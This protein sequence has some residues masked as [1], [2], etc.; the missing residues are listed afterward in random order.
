MKYDSGTIIGKRSRKISKV[1]HLDDIK[2]KPIYIAMLSSIK[3]LTKQN[4]ELILNN[5]SF[6]EL[7]EN[8]IDKNIISNI[9]K[10]LPKIEKKRLIVSKKQSE[11]VKHIENKEKKIS[12]IGNKICNDIFKFFVNTAV[13]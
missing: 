9:Q 3:G 12:I 2:N 5:I 6:Q 1:Q 13:L 10:I 7:L 11:T 8:K 4:A